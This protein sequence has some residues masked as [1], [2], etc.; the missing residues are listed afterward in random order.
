MRRSPAKRP[1]QADIAR[2]AGVSQAT[3]SLVLNERDAGVRI[4]PATRERVLTVMREWGYVANASARSL[5]GGRNKIIGVYTFEPVFPTSGVDFYFPFLLG[6]EQEAAD[7]GYDLLL[8]TSAGGERQIFRDGSTRLWHA[9]GALLLGRDPNVEEIEQLRDSGFPFVY[10]GHRE[11]AGP[12]VSYVAADY[13]GA[14]RQLTERLFQLGHQRVA[15]ARIG[16]GVAQPS[17]DR[18]QGFRRA[19]PSRHL[20]GPVWTLDSVA[21]VD[22]LFEELQRAGVT[23]VLAEQQLLAE[24]LLSCTRRR[25]LSVPDDLSV[26]VLGDSTG[27]RQ[28]GTPWTGLIVP[29]EQMGQRATALLVRQLE[30]PDASAPNSGA[31]DEGALDEGA[32]R[33]GGLSESVE[34]CFAVGATVGPPKEFS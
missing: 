26:V 4:S 13:A 32:L 15:Y 14:T 31:P 6:M 2:L 33:S 17:R 20:T 29:R 9:D 3:V 25:G 8:F 21:E 27:A 23:A 16:N 12:P 30:A 7:L 24:E 34:C 18:E 10:V 19:T 28:D 5:A 22:G 11:V 1:T